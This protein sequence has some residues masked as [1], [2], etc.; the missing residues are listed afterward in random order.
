[1]GKRSTGKGKAKKK[2]GENSTGKWGKSFWNS[3]KLKIKAK[4]STEKVKKRS[5]G[6]MRKR[7]KERKA[8]GLQVKW[9]KLRDK[10]EKIRKENEKKT[11]SGIIGKNFSGIMGNFLLDNGE[12]LFRDNG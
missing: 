2:Y 9:G 12:K 7:S 6:V 5:T 11:S 3:G 4:R 8:K 10:W 1:M